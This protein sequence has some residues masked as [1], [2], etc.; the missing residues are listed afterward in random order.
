MYRSCRPGRVLVGNA[1]GPTGQGPFALPSRMGEGFGA[2]V[3]P[4]AVGGLEIKAF[5][6]ERAHE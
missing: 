5:D 3:L 4:S 6:Y 1:K 2:L